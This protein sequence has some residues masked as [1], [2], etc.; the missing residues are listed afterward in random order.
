MDKYFH[1]LV[2]SGVGPMIMDSELSAV[3]DPLVFTDRKAQIAIYFRMK[4]SR[5]AVDI[6]LNLKRTCHLTGDFS[7]IEVYADVSFESFFSF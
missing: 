2:T 7:M 5:K 1:F 4:E 3:C 6:L